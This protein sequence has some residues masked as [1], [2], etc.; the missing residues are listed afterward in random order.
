MS[1]PRQTNNSIST[2]INKAN[3]KCCASFWSAQTVVLKKL[4]DWKCYDAKS[5]FLESDKKFRTWILRASSTDYSRGGD[6][7]TQSAIA[8]HLNDFDRKLQECMTLF[9]YLINRLH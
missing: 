4:T 5:D 1:D 6:E 9:E 2:E 8:R 3:Q 7:L